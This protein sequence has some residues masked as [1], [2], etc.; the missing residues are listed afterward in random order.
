M[1]KFSGCSHRVLSGRLYS[2]S[3][4]ATGCICSTCV[5]TTLSITVIGMPSS[6]PQMPHNQAQN[7]SEMNTAAAFILA[8]FPVIQVVTKVPTTMAIVNDAPETSNI[9]ENE[10]NCMKAAIP[11]VAAMAN[12]PR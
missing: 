6:M 8:I 9:I 7:S 2:P 12:G 11:V 10:S 1:K 3:N 4:S 5:E